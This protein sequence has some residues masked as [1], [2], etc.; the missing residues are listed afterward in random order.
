[1]LSV[2]PTH[3]SIKS[4]APTAHAEDP[5]DVLCRT[6]RLIDDGRAARSFFA[7]PVHDAEIEQLIQEATDRAWALAEGGGPR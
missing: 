5:I 4:P 7:A 3:R 2:S 1:M 6:L